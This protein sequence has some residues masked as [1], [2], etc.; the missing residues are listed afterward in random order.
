MKRGFRN[1]ISGNPNENY[2][3]NTKPLSRLDDGEG[4]VDELRQQL[5]QKESLLTETRLEALTSA[6]QLQTLRETIAKLR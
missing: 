1:P 4:S 5:I 2:G 3:V 6:H